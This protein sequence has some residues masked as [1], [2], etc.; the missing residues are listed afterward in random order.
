[1]YSHP[2]LKPT[3]TAVRQLE[4]L[5]GPNGDSIEQCRQTLW[6]ALDGTAGHEFVYQKNEE[7]YI[8]TV[9]LSANEVERLLAEHGYQR[10]F[11]S[12]V[13]EID[14]HTAYSAWVQDPPRFEHDFPESEG[15]YQ[16]DVYLLKNGDKTDVYAHFEN[17]VR[18]PEKHLNKAGGTGIPQQNHYIGPLDD[19]LPL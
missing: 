7:D 19:I 18:A 2:L 12:A 17:S 15:P 14:G 1:M 4:P 3:L 8:G 13:K 11:A 16:H 5:F 6:Y 9:E 10:N